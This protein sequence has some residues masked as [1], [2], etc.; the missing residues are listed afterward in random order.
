MVHNYDAATRA[1][2]VTL[3]AWGA[4]NK[5]ITSIVGHKI[6]SS[7]PVRASIL[8]SHSFTPSRGCAIL[9]RAWAEPERNLGSQEGQ[10]WF[11][12]RA[13]FW[14][15]KCDVSN[16]DEHSH[17][18]MIFVIKAISSTIYSSSSFV[19]TPVN[20]FL[21]SDRSEIC[22]VRGMY[23]FWGFWENLLGDC[24][25][26]RV[27]TI[28]RLEFRRSNFT[29]QRQFQGH[30]SKPN[31]CGFSVARPITWSRSFSV[32]LKFRY[33]SPFLLPLLSASS[34]VTSRVLPS[35]QSR[36]IPF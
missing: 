28:S 18:D 36:C 26:V 17:L 10:A 33:T 16:I 11:P 7:A 20:D 24:Q 3:K 15:F 13:G 21:E 30:F 34:S 22:S 32:N 6:F 4:T 23:A 8:S 19:I 1:Q 12:V 31:P 2:V 9:D 27:L 35:Y 14:P 29:A 25:A 5:Q